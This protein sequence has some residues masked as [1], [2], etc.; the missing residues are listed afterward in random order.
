MYAL[1]PHTCMADDFHG[2]LAKYGVR[3]AER[4][5]VFTS[6]FAPSV[7]WIMAL[8]FEPARML[9]AGIRHRP[10]FG[11]V[12]THDEAD[13]GAGALALGHRRRGRGATGGTTG[14]VRRRSQ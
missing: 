6:P 3:S 11:V 7:N 5:D 1:H 12:G 9:R 2:S 10:C 8:P 4:R 14:G 13:T